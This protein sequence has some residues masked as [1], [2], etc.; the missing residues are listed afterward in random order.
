MDAFG[1]FRKFRRVVSFYNWTLNDAVAFLLS[2]DLFELYLVVTFYINPMN[3]HRQSH[4]SH[5]ITSHHITSH[6]ITS[7]HITSH[8]ITSH[9]ITSHHITSHHITSHHI[10]SHHALVRSGPNTKL[11]TPLN[12]SSLESSI[13]VTEPKF[14]SWSRYCS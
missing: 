13:I 1:S 2:A 3:P 14:I 12:R 5:H 7:H 4:T 11:L 10:T 8:H 6:H 9:H